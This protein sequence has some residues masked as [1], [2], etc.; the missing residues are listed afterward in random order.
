MHV[1]FGLLWEIGVVRT[2]K[3]ILGDLEI[4][5][6]RGWGILESMDLLD[7]Q[8]EA[9]GGRYHLWQW[10]R[11]M[12]TRL[13]AV[14]FERREIHA[15]LTYPS[16][17]KK[18]IKI[19]GEW[20][21]SR[22]LYMLQNLT[23]LPGLTFYVKPQTDIEWNFKNELI[24]RT[25]QARGVRKCCPKLNSKTTLLYVSKSGRNRSLLL[26]PSF[27]HIFS[28]VVRPEKE[29]G[30]ITRY[31]AYKIRHLSFSNSPILWANSFDYTDR[32]SPRG[33]HRSDA[34]TLSEAAS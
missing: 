20:R 1:I 2:Q 8:P 7:L 15:K 23:R 17:I 16:F 19:Q 18:T 5:L 27:T 22:K 21:I 32:E 4:G 14:I 31:D 30:F 33:G 24:D 13:G 12:Y 10:E 6:R 28:S 3:D 9:N 25:A 34:V 11:S 26:L 29:S